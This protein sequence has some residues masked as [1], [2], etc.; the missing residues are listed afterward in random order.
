MVLFAAFTALLHRY[1]DQDDI[2]VGTPSS[3]RTHKALEPLIGFFINTVILR[4]STSGNPTFIELV[5]R[6]RETATAAFANQDVP[7]EKIVEELQPPRDTSRTPYSQRP[8]QLF[9]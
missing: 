7:F 6:V 4:V 5:R 9:A 3:G 2:V 1:T 8:V